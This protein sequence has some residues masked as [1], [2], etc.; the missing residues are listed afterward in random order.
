M[1]NNIVKGQ[2]GE[3]KVLDRCIVVGYHFFNS[4]DEI[5]KYR[6]FRLKSNLKSMDNVLNEAIK[7]MKA[8][9]LVVSTIQ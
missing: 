2:Y 9:G 6:Y 1:N 5:E 7:V 3:Y 4:I 8:N